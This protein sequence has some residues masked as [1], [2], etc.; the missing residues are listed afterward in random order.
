MQLFTPIK[1]SPQLANDNTPVN[2]ISHGQSPL[3]FIFVW[4]SG[5]SQ[6]GRN[7]CSPQMVLSLLY[8]VWKVKYRAIARF[9]L[10]TSYNALLPVSL[11]I[12]CSFSIGLNFKWHV[13]L[14]QTIHA[15][16]VILQ[17]RKKTC[18]V[19]RCLQGIYCKEDW[20]FSFKSL[21][22]R[23]LK[24][25]ISSTAF[26]KIEKK[27]LMKPDAGLSWITIS[28]RFHWTQ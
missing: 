10:F 26:C 9:V 12:V 14:C 8:S 24:S 28:D 7:V 21:I 2:S 25:T 18:Y 22:W 13:L 19:H 5:L 16:S 23:E 15:P 20:V 3:H 17:P 11:T 6:Q 1:W 27:V 4:E